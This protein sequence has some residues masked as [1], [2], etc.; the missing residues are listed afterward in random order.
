[1]SLIRVD[2]TREDWQD[3]DNPVRSSR[4]FSDNRLSYIN[5]HYEGTDRIWTDSFE[6]WLLYLQNLFLGRG[7]S[8]GYSYAVDNRDGQTAEIRG[9]T[10][11]A[12]SNGDREDG[13]DAEPGNPG[14][15]DNDEVISIIVLN[16]GS[17]LTDACMASLVRLCRDIVAEF[18]DRDLQIN[19]H[20]DM[21]RTPCP[22]ETVYRELEELNK[23][24]FNDSPVG[25]SGVFLEDMELLGSDSYRM[26][27]LSHTYKIGKEKVY[28]FDAPEGV[29]AVLANLTVIPVSEAGHLSVWN[30][31]T[32]CINWSPG[33][34][35]VPNCVPIVCTDG[36]LTF[37]TEPQFQCRLI[38][39]IV[40]VVRR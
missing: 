25:G 39:D 1:M 15:W 28:E 22:G 31:E 7:Y 30:D 11:R 19:G 13:D 8:A 37:Y 4:V 26:G 3:P 32:S 33:V 38:I 14:Y 16:P 5:L 23:L 18:P 12:A 35:P 36:K 34:G 29:D 40:G 10:Y 21:D 9:T 17:M 24:V 2:L 27:G 6:E 20:R